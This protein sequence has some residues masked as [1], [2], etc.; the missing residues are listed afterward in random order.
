MKNYKRFF[1]L[2]AI[3][4]FFIFFALLQVNYIQMQ[5]VKK[6]ML[7][8]QA[9]NLVYFVNSFREVYQE[10]FIKNH[11]KI[12]EKTINLIPVA[13]IPKI[14]QNFSKKVNGTIKIKLISQRPRNPKNMANNEELKILNQ[15]QK[16]KNPYLYDLNDTFIYYEPLYIKKSCLACHNT[17]KEAPKYIQDNYKTSYGY[18]IGDLKGAIVVTIKDSNFIGLLQNNFKT[19]ILGSIILYIVILVVAFFLLKRLETIDKKYIKKLTESNQKLSIEKQRAQEAL[20]IKSEFLANMSHEIRTP[21][22]AM[23][24]FIKLLE[25]K[26]LDK[27]SK[28]YLEIVEKSGETVLNVINDILDFSKI[29]SGKLKIE[30]ITFNPKSEIEIIYNLFEAKASESNINLFIKEH[31]LND[32]IVSDPIRIKQVISNLLSNA[33]KFTPRDKNVYLTIKYENEYL[34]VEVKDEG[35]GIPKEKLITIFEAFTQADSSTTRKYGGTGLGLTISYKLIKLLGGE[36]KVESEVNKGSKFYFTIPAKKG[37]KVIKKEKQKIDDEKFNF[38]L[39]LA[40][41]NKANQM[42][43]QVIL[44]KLG[45]TFDIANDGV[46]AFDMYKKNYDKYDLILMDENMPNMTGSEATKKIREFEK[47]NNLKP[48]FIVAVTA[49][50]LSGDKE[51]FLEAGMDEYLSKPLD[52]FKLKD[53]LRKLNEYNHNRFK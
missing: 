13:N 11:I 12:D 27:E 39:L 26:N 22:N 34:Y 36:L 16:T 47:E 20:K 32:N 38:H 15:F 30:K 37:Q 50:A 10:D 3:I 14:A 48:I 41:D 6:E 53:I 1:Y 19:R 7:K 28:K 23:F 21:L 31:N 51:K 17:P 40:E 29:E 33:I 52:I 18:K 9:S 49:N 43:M 4:L 8:T 45:L 5:K 25:E 44:K 2:F 24:G 35:I 46:E 42:F